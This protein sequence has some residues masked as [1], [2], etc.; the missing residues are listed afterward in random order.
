[1]PPTPRAASFLDLNRMEWATSFAPF[2]RAGKRRCPRFA[3]ALARFGVTRNVA[4]L[5]DGLPICAAIGDSHAA[6]FGHRRLQPGDGKVTFGT[7]SSIRMTTLRGFIAPER[8]ITTTVAWS[9]NGQPT[10]AFEGNI[11]VSAAAL[12]WMADLLGLPDVQALTDLAPAPTRGPALSPPCRSWRAY[13]AADARALFSG[14]TFT[15]SAPD[16]ARRHRTAWRFRFM[17]SLRPCRRSRP[18][19]WPALRR[20]RSQPEPF[21][22]QCVADMLDHPLIQC[23][24]PEA[25]ALGAAYLAG[26]TLG[27]GPTWPPSP[28]APGGNLL[29]PRR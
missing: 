18:P 1:M 19:A 23:D 3:T 22:M 9:I 2:R 6:L 29:P 5:P 27:S 25:S 11:L 13:W 4:C 10:Y 21:L 16:G 8:G 7:G 28:P 15:T 24:A 14:I 26:L 12:P 20:W 17:T